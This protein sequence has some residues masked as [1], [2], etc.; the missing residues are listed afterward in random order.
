V[1]LWDI[2]GGKATRFRQFMDTVKFLEIVPAE[3]SKA[4]TAG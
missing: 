4:A 2:R 3:V 1:H